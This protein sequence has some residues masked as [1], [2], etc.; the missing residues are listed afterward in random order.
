MATAAD[1]DK[2]VSRL[3]KQ[4][5][6]QDAQL[7]QLE[8]QLALVDA[9]IDEYDELIIKMDNKS[10]GLIEELNDAIN[11]VKDAYLARISAGCRSDLAWIEQ[12]PTKFQSLSFDDDDEFTIY[13]VDKNPE[14]YD[15]LGYYGMKYFRYPKNIEYGANVTDTLPNCNVDLFSTAV[16]LIPQNPAPIGGSG[17]TYFETTDAE[18]QQLSNGQKTVKVGDFITDDLREPEY[19]QIG[20]L[21]KIVGFGTTSYPGRRVNLTGFTTAADNKIYFDGI[22]GGIATVA[23]VGD[24][25]YDRSGN[26]YVANG[27]YIQSIGV[28]TISQDVINASG[29]TTQIT[30]NIDFVVLNNVSLGTTENHTF[31]VGI[32]STYDTIFISTGPVSKAV[33]G[34]SLLA[35]RPPEVG[36]IEFNATAS[37]ID[38]VEI[39]IVQGNDIG[40]GHKIDLINNGVENKK[41]S[42]HEQRYDPDP[43]YSDEP[44]HPEPAV[45]NGRASYWIG[46]SLW[47]QLTVN[48]GED[49]DTFYAPI[50][51]TAIVGSANTAGASVSITYT[52][53][54]P[55]NPSLNGCGSLDTAITNAEAA[56]QVVIDKNV[57]IIENYI[58]GAKALRRLRNEEETTAWSF[59]QGIGFINNKKSTLDNEANEL[60]SLDWKDLLAD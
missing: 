53:I 54:S 14:V 38:P 56:L 27:S 51:E 34:D 35:L 33:E 46:N 42:W 50:G 31:Q 29:I 10:P 36:D 6:Q 18:T 41:D 4:R 37:P 44:V 30:I 24:F 15:F 1:P 28:S 21:P 5:D 16:V 23:R 22:V 43:P 57:P 32:V 17:T 49:S 2:I 58:Q 8:E 48:D 52:S 59:Q 3:R 40:K 45:G 9:I 20:D 25:V 60:E 13:K 47:P 7:E 19:F 55:T 11:V 39:G 12:E 26:G